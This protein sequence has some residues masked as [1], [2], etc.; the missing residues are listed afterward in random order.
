[1]ADIASDAPSS[2]ASTCQSPAMQTCQQA[3]CILLCLRA[4]QA[5]QASIVA[6][7]LAARLDLQRVREEEQK[8]AAAAHT[9][10]Q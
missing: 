5:E 1:M 9:A 8:A 2:L 10:L 6:E 7:I 3:C 4:A